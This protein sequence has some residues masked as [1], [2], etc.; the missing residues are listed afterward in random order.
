MAYEY[1]LHDRPDGHPQTA[2]QVWRDA[3]TVDQLASKIRRHI[4]SE[5]RNES[6]PFHELTQVRT[7]ADAPYLEAL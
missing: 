5:R 3:H 7:F 2:A 1:Y 6:N 4:L